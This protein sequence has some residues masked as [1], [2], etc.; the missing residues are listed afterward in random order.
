MP[1]RQG[2]QQRQR[3]RVSGSDFYRQH[4]AL[5]QFTQH[6]LSEFNRVLQRGQLSE[7]GTQTATDS[8]G[9]QN[10]NNLSFNPHLS[11]T[12]IF[13]SSRRASDSAS[14]QRQEQELGR[15]VGELREW[16]SY[17]S[18]I[19]EPGTGM[20]PFYSDGRWEQVRLD[21]SQQ[22]QQQ[23]QQQPMVV[24][25]N[26]DNEA[27]IQSVP[28]VRAATDW[29]QQNLQYN[30]GGGTQ[31]LGQPMI[32]AMDPCPNLS[33]E[34]A[35]QLLGLGMNDQNREGDNQ[36]SGENLSWRDDEGW[37][38]AVEEYS[39]ALIHMQDRLAQVQSVQHTQE[40]CSE[41][42]ECQRIP[43]CSLLSVGIVFSGHQMVRG[44]SWE[45]QEKQNRWGVTVTIQ[46][47]NMQKGYVCGIMTARDVPGASGPILTFWSGE[48]IDNINHT[49]TTGK[50][51]AKPTDDAH[52]WALFPSHSLI[53]ENVRQ[54]R[55]TDLCSHSHIY[56]RWKEQFFVHDCPNSRLTISGFY[57]VALN[58]QTGEIQGWYF[59]RNFGRSYQEL[60]LHTQ[61][62]D[63]LLGGT[64]GLGSVSD[65]GSMRKYSERELE[66]YGQ[67]FPSYSFY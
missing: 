42:V 56:M 7:G 63:V 35:Y 51:G 41:V 57:Y 1:Q 53:A 25:N 47:C 19:Q 13:D 64:N 22:Q 16:H 49:F 59:D 66:G 54:G 58:R 67:S 38:D 2:N 23:Y 48:I 31:V 20:V 11:R 10:P 15:N 52:Y 6:L 46:D 24:D 44:S 26:N 65:V 9:T 5:N 36:D 45:D 28:T 60:K 21:Q 17:L 27:Q 62:G 55:C 3:P 32:N 34:D 50:W 14:L 29:Y 12:H 18:S 61:N 43:S 37:V 39:N 8:G 33:E 30:N 4:V 40:E